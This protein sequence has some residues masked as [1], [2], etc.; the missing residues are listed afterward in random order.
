MA[1]TWAITQS[2][3]QFL[4]GD[5]FLRDLMT[6]ARAKTARLEP[7]GDVVITIHDWGMYLRIFG[8]GLVVK[9][10]KVVKGSV[11]GFDFRGGFG[12]GW[13]TGELDGHL[14]AAKFFELAQSKSKWV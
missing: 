14:S 4:L 10:W 5:D 6:T 9:D 11:T 13:T 7:S 8:E 12:S 3:G 1:R 2:D